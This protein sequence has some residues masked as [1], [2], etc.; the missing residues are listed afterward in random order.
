MTVEPVVAPV[1]PAKFRNTVLTAI[2]GLLG[3]ILVG[4]LA[5]LLSWSAV[6]LYPPLH[7][8]PPLQRLYP[9]NPC[10]LALILAVA[11]GGL[12]YFSVRKQLLLEHRLYYLAGVAGRGAIARWLLTLAIIFGV[13][14]GFVN[15][16]L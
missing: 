12:G 8:A 1:T 14:A 9:T 4:A 15:Y 3:A 2:S 6:F 13:A 10:Y 16:Q 7:V 5:W 11:V